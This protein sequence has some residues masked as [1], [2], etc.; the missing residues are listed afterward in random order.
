[1]KFYKIKEELRKLRE[2]NYKLK[3][4]IRELINE[5]D[6]KEIIKKIKTLKKE[7]G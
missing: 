5:S 7:Y 4:I 2:E 1:V 6:E 3:K